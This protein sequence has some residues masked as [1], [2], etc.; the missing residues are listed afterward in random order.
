MAI[1]AATLLV[2]VATDIGT[3]VQDL[4]RVGSAVTTTGNLSKAA[5]L[6]AVGAIAGIGVASV[7]TAIQFE[8]ATNTIR[9]GTG[10]TGAELE[11]LS[12]SMRNVF[13]ETPASIDQVA[14]AITDLSTRTGASGKELEDLSLTMLRLARMTNTEVA[15]LIQSTTRLFG[16]WGIAAADQIP[17]LDKLWRAA[18]AS[19]IGVDALASQMV[20]AGVQFRLLGFDFDTTTALLAKFEE[21]GVNSEQVVGTLRMGLAKMAREGFPDLNSAFVEIT[22]RIKNATSETDA[23]N[24]ANEYFGSRAGVQMAGA[25]REGRF[26]VEEFVKSIAGGKDTIATAAGDTSTFASKLE[27]MKHRLQD[28]I[29]PIGQKL[30]DALDRFLKVMMPVVEVLAPFADKIAIAG[31]ATFAL[32]KG[33]KM[34]NAAMNAFKAISAAMTMSNPWLL[35]LVAV[36]GAAV[37]IYKNWDK[38]WPVIEKVGRWFGDV[39][40]KMAEVVGDF[41][42]KVWDIGAKI[43]GGIWEGMKFAFNVF[44]TWYVEIPLKLIGWL[45]QG[46]A[47]IWTV[48]RDFV[49]G[50]WNGIVGAWTWMWENVS[51]F[52]VNIWNTVVDVLGNVW[53]IGRDFLRG[54]WNGI[55]GAWEWFTGKV[56]GA[57][58]GF[59]NFITFGIF[60]E[61][62][63]SKVFARIGENVVKGLGKGVGG[64]GAWDRITADITSRAGDMV[65]SVRTRAGDIGTVARDTIDGIASK[66][67]ETGATWAETA[68]Q[69]I[70]QL[71]GGLQSFFASEDFTARLAAIGEQMTAGLS[72]GWRRLEEIIGGL[73]T[74]ISTALDSAAA[75][76]VT[77]LGEMSAGIVADA[78]A[79]LGPAGEAIPAAITDAALPGAAAMPEVLADAALPGAAEFGSAVAGTMSASLAGAPEWAEATTIARGGAQ[80]IIDNALAVAAGQAP[81]VGGSIASGI[82][83]G[84]EFSPEWARARSVAEGGAQSIVDAVNRVIQP[85]SPSKVFTAIGRSITDGLALGIMQ[86]AGGPP[87]AL[88]AVAGGLTFPGGAGR[89]GSGSGQPIVI[90][91]HGNL[92]HERELGGLV[93]RALASRKRSVPSLSFETA[94]IR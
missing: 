25:I 33:V 75:T 37:L 30:V 61:R 77:K 71:L 5:N 51:R 13:R 41:L 1:D 56:A 70:G 22:N 46:L 20:T 15:P 86:G 90:N 26:E 64:R 39:F 62:S 83:D 17:T 34:V 57:F 14:T 11:G 87:A 36:A 60:E 16:D 18:Q 88:G 19:G 29:E 43:I 6:A 81:G 67:A 24:I 55:A 49:V 10:A 2:T 12:E 35:L 9:K 78:P 4:G 27:I 38:I 21:E 73:G 59:I 76:I 8:N 84:I 42:G 7:N 3:T 91:V 54:L 45:V 93:D 94:G 92:I 85:G 66:V 28:A 23:L 50:I 72:G 65:D 80:T 74:T 53:E 48:G 58:R 79:T 63:P 69:F 68:R 32:V 44:W 40:G 52:A 89:S 31:V 82:A 47:K